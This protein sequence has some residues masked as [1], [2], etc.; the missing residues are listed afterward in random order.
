MSLRIKPVSKT[1]EKRYQANPHDDKRLEDSIRD[2]DARFVRA[3]A[4]AYQAGEFPGSKP[5]QLIG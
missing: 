5:F 3:L 2:A 1:Y 4:Q